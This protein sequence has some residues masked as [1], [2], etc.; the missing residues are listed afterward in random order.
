MIDTNAGFLI[1]RIKQIGSRLFDRLLA[2]KNIG[3]FNG[4]Q[5]RIL[6]VLWQADG[7]SLSEIAK[8]SGLATAT[9]TSMIDRMEAAGLVRREAHATDRRKFQIV[10]TEKARALE[11]EYKAVSDETTAP[12]FKGF[13]DEEIRAFE[14]YLRRVLENLEEAEK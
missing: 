2:E 12:H 1:S 7:V 3:A 6:Y 11:A 8:N 9:L 14:G 10:L 5:G 4:A 13:S